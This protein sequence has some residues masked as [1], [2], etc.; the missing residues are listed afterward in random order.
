MTAPLIVILAGGDGQ[1]M[2]G[3]KPLRALSAFSE[4]TLE[5]FESD[6]AAVTA[7]YRELSESR[8]AARRRRKK[9]DKKK[10]GKKKGGKK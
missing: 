1:R 6:A 2:G 4:R 9:K 7:A 8:R 5:G 3:A 10:S